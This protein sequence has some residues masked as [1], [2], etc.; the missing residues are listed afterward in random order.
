MG[1]PMR[2]NLD[3]CDTQLPTTGDFYA[4]SAGVPDTLREKYLPSAMGD[5]S[6]LFLELIR[7][8]IAQTN[9]LSKHYRIRQMQPN[10]ADVAGI[11]QQISAIHD[12]VGCFRYSEDRTV[13]YHAYHLELFLQ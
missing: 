1:R 5:L 13:C 9:I 10:A 2:I 3:D 6:Q 12:K 4:M 8:A 7:L 11:E